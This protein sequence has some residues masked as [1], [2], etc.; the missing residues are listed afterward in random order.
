M[1][2]WLHNTMHPFDLDGLAIM[3]YGV[4]SLL[5]WRRYRAKGSR[6]Q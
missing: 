4:L 1:I 3:A 5:G 6:K 2:E